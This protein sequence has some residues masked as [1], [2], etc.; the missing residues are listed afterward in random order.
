MVRLVLAVSC[1]GLLFSSTAWADVAPFGCGCGGNVRPTPLPCSAEAMTSSYRVCKECAPSD[2]ACRDGLVKEGYASA[3]SE[4]N[5]EVF[6]RTVGAGVPDASASRTG[7]GATALGL[8]LAGT[9]LVKR[10]RG[11]LG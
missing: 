9:V 2:A 4:G 1:A 5:V 11:R 10:R 3:C 6:C 7:F 8:A